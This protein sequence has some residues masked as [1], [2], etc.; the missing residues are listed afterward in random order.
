MTVD[1]L[2]LLLRNYAVVGVYSGGT[3]PEEDAAAWQ[4]LLELADK[5]SIRTPI[6]T[7]SGFDEV[8]GVLS[9]LTSGGPAGKQIIDISWTHHGRRRV[10]VIDQG[11]PVFRY[12]LDGSRLSGTVEDQVERRCNG[13]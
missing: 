10:T 6:G 8:P 9:R 13:P 3:T 7:V 2:D 5:G 1:T 4:R 11:G 12:T